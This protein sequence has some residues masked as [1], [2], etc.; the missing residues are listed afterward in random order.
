[1][2]DYIDRELLIENIRKHTVLEPWV[3]ELVCTVIKDVPDVHTD[4]SIY[5]ALLEHQDAE[6]A[7]LKRKPEIKEGMAVYCNQCSRLYVLDKRRGS[8][9]RI[10]DDRHDSLIVMND[11][12]HYHNMQNGDGGTCVDKEG[13]GYV[14]LRT[15]DGMLGSDETAPYG[16]GI[17]ERFRDQIEKYIAEQKGAE[18]GKQQDIP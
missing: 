11:E 8:I 13:Y 6:I 9:H 1:M 2:S 7:A 18:N 5:R 15:D 17:D 14:I 10:G 4:I 16:F 12:V 3:K